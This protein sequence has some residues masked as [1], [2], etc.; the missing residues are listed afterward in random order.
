MLGNEFKLIEYVSNNIEM[1][2]NLQNKIEEG[3]IYYRYI[4]PFY[5]NNKNDELKK[6]LL[7]I[8][9]NDEVLASKLEKKVDDYVKV[10]YSIS[11]DLNLI[12]NDLRKYL[13]DTEKENIIF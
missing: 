3:N 13:F 4:L 8:S 6:K 5:L 12:Y 10:I 9:L 7:L 2:S 11:R 1:I